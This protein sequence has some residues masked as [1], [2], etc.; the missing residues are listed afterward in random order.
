MARDAALLA[1]A[2]TTGTSCLRLY[3]WEPFCL[4]FGRH[5]PA[6]RRYRRER[7]DELGIDCVRRPTGGRAVWHARELTYAVAAPLVAFGGLREAYHQIHEALGRALRRLG[8]QPLLAPASSVLPPHAGACFAAPVGGEVLLQ[9][10]KAVGSAQVRQGDAFLQH[11]SVLLE[12]NQSLVSELAGLPATPG[13]EIT[14]AEALGRR[15]TFDE[16]AAAVRT[17]WIDGVGAE[18]VAEG[19]CPGLDALA[20]ELGDRFRNPA[21]TWSR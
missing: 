15:V 18:L 14:L 11:G 20:D 17:E 2:A 10:R 19:P 1:L 9:G 12:D 6:G 7:I 16:A 4:S 8:A 13:G 21:W 5:E 3:Q